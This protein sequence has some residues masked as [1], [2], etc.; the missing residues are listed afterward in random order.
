MGTAQE[1]ALADQ[2]IAEAD[3]KARE[4]AEAAELAERVRKAEKEWR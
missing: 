4:R 2:L 3:R 1:K